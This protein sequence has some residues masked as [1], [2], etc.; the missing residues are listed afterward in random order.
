MYWHGVKKAL[1]KYSALYTLLSMYSKAYLM[2]QCDNDCRGRHSYG[3]GRK[4]IPMLRFFFGSTCTLGMWSCQDKDCPATC[5]I[6]GGSHINTYDDKSYTFHGECSYVLS[7]VS[8]SCQ[9]Q[10]YREHT[11]VTLTCPCWPRTL[12]VANYSHENIPY[13]KNVCRNV[14]WNILYN[15]LL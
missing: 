5:A 7:R 4:G 15:I 13:I 9:L 2:Q 14:Y 10:G 6:V 1:V 12:G 3:T 11:E 8:H